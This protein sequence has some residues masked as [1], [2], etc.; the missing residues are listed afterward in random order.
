MKCLLIVK[1]ITIRFV[2]LTSSPDIFE[3]F[4]AIVLFAVFVGLV[5]APAIPAPFTRRKRSDDANCKKKYYGFH[6]FCSKDFCIRT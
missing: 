2:A 1:P 4:R 6:V 5:I 3:C